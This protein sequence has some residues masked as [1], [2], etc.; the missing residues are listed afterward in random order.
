MELWGTSLLGA[1]LST[2]CSEAQYIEIRETASGRSTIDSIGLLSVPAQSLLEAS[3][4]QCLSSIHAITLNPRA[5]MRS[6]LGPSTHLARDSDSVSAQH[7]RLPGLHFS[8][9][10]RQTQRDN[11]GPCESLARPLCQKL[12]FPSDR[13]LML[14]LRH[15]ITSSGFKLA[16]LEL[17]L[18]LMM[19]I[20]R[21]TFMY[22]LTGLFPLP[23]FS[24]I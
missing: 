11:R 4:R 9:P 18:G 23:I 3:V 10:V 5:L 14:E 16:V 17:V 12:I 7:K 19:P 22:Y 15:C 13:S 6:Q 1:K 20:V 8:L 21:K 24:G 2:T